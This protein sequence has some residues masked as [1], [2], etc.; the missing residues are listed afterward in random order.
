[1]IEQFFCYFGS[2]CFRE[3][4]EIMYPN[5]KRRNN[6]VNAYNKAYPDLKKVVELESMEALELCKK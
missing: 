2:I 6:F 1:M 4:D 5:T 3:N